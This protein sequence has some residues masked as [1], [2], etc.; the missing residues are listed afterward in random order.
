MDVYVLSLS[1]SLSL[2]FIFI[3]SAKY[4]ELHREKE[5]LAKLL[6]QERLRIQQE[7][8]KGEEGFV[9]KVH[10]M[11]AQLQGN[12]LSLSLSLTL[13]LSLLVLY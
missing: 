4:E 8:Q 9:H 3:T 12:S 7:L 1:L 6:E 13:S 10:E 5:E 2:S 11:E